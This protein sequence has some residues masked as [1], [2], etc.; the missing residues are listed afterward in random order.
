MCYAT[1]KAALPA[2]GDKSLVMAKGLASPPAFG[3]LTLSSL[4]EK[5]VEGKGYGK[6]SANWKT[7]LF[8]FSPQSVRR[9]SY[10]KSLFLIECSSGGYTN[11]NADGQNLQTGNLAKADTN[12][13]H[14]RFKERLSKSDDP[15]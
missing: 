11:L 14:Q 2:F 1:F 9:T 8:I 15:L 4:Y 6:R 5:G 12:I 3:V 13:R 10:N 7:H